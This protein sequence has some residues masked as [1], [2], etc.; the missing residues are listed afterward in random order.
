MDTERH[1]AEV[2]SLRDAYSRDQHWRVPVTV[3]FDEQFLLHRWGVSFGKYYRDVPTQVAVQLRSQQWIRET[4]VQDAPRG[5]PDQWHLAVPSWTEENAFFGA[6]VAEQENDY[7]WGQPLVLGKS[8][9][10]RHLHG[11][12]VE[13]RLRQGTCYQQYVEMKR[14]VDGMEH[15]GRPVVIAP[16]PL[17]STHGLFT[18]AAE[19]RGLEQ[20]CVDLHED[21]VFVRELLTTVTE[22]TIQRIKC[23]QVLCGVERTFPMEGGWG[24]CDDSLQL[25]S[26][27]H[28]EEFVLPCH[29]RIYSEM[30]TGTRH[31]HLCGH[32]QHLF[33][34]LHQ[35]LAITVFDGP[36]TQVDLPRRIG[37]IGD[38]V[39]IQ[40]QVSHG[41]LASS[42]NAIESAVRQVLDERV[43]RGARMTL[44][45]YAPRAAPLEN[46]QF[47]YECARAHGV[48]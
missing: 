12:D 22:L 13:E 27:A 46:L 25:I 44:L 7:W 42:R 2:A 26:R 5:L 14:L 4:I 8:K 23:W 41:L 15:C 17:L 39:T 38:R 6:E 18:K 11:L 28:Y 37:D 9:L 40:A 29:Q 30:T 10:L 16:P 47:F 45:G 32:V 20:L 43:K 21:P 3:A 35:A 19:I 31:V 36:G 33:K 48:L 34:T 1:N 24:L